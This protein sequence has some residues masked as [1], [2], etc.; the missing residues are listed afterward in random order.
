MLPV[1]VGEDSCT[2]TPVISPAISP[3][4]IES[5]K[6]KRGRP[7]GTNGKATE[8][9]PTPRR[10]GRPP[11]TG[12]KQKAQAL[13][14]LS[15]QLQDSDSEPPAKRCPGR[16]QKIRDAAV[17]VSIEYGRMVCALLQLF[18]DNNNNFCQLIGC[19]WN[20]TTDGNS[21]R[22]SDVRSLH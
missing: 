18:F 12:Y 10:L 9:N 6:R 22:E 2:N 17:G 13:L 8:L 3:P 5:R 1:N 7:K 21:S 4:P 19:T 14:A 16:P 11:G 15:G 20:T